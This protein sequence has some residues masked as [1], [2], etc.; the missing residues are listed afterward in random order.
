MGTSHPIIQ[1]GAP[2]DIR[3]AGSVVLADISKSASLFNDRPAIS[4][5]F[6]LVSKTV[7]AQC[8]LIFFLNAP[9][10]AKDHIHWALG[11]Y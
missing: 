6:L 1:E 5:C 2:I 7:D 11:K 4:R 10:G 8:V 9:L 3:R